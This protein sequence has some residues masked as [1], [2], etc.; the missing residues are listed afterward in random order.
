[1]PRYF[2]PSGRYMKFDG[3]GLKKPAR[4]LGDVIEETSQYTKHL[5]GAVNLKP[6]QPLLGQKIVGDNIRQAS[7]VIK[8]FTTA[9]SSSMKKIPL[10]AATLGDNAPSVA[11]LGKAIGQTKSLVKNVSGLFRGKGMEQKNNIRLVL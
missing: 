2:K 4:I 11:H 7:N 1:M 5:N 9:V 6:L 8:P 3:K 10:S